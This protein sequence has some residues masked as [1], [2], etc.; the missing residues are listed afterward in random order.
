VTLETLVGQRIQS[1]GPL[2]VA[3][4]MELALYHPD[5]GYY[6]QAAQRSGAGRDFYISVKRGLSS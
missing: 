3:A 1:Q 4:F 6:A 2:T 5:R